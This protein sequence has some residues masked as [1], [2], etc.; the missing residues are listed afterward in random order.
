MAT[1]RDKSMEPPGGWIYVQPESKL[2]IRDENLPQL[3]AQVMAHRVHMGYPRSD[4]VS[5]TID[6]E[7]QI[8]TRLGTHD[9]NAEHGDTWVPMK[10]NAGLGLSGVLAFS[11]GAFDWF[12]SGRPIVSME[13]NQRRRAICSIC[14]LNQPMSGCRCAPLYKAIAAVVPKERQFDDLHVCEACGCAL[15]A[16]CAVPADVLMTMDEGRDVVYPI[17]CWCPEELG[18]G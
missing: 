14:P 2:V 4:Q 18:K 12:T 10:T 11:K 5:V 13:E 1:L 15:K 7:R 16:K 9:C 8:C 17:Q 3:I 6:V